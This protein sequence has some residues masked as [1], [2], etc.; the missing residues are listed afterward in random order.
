MDIKNILKYNYNELK[1]N[2]DNNIKTK[3]INIKKF[4]RDLYSIEYKSPLSPTNI[5]LALIVY[6]ICFAIIIP[7][8]LLKYNYYDFL[9]SYL[10]NLDLVAN[11]LSFHGSL[12]LNKFFLELYSPTPLNKYGFISKN[13]INY[14]ALL[15]LTFIIARETKLSGSI[16]QGWSLGFVMLIMTYLFPGQ[17][18]SGIMSYIYDKLYLKYKDFIINKPYNLYKIYLSTLLIGIILTVGIILLEKKVIKYF[19]KNL[20]NIAEYII[21]IP[22]II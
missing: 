16:A 9:E 17:I 22:K 10:P 7:Y 13:I 2:I 6:I 21:N 19:R 11:L 14:L 5:I 18:I 12:F 3:K 15:G 4:G 1:D 20:I 8:F